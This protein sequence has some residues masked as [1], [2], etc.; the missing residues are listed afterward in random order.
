[1]KPRILQ[2]F[3]RYLAPGGEDRVTQLIETAL[4]D[5][6]QVDTHL[7]STEALLGNS[8][9]DRALAP[10][11]AVHNFGAARD[12]E[13]L[14]EKNRYSLWLIHNVLPGLSPSVYA[15]AFRL[16]V[17]VV[18]YLHNFR[19]MCTNGLLLNHG[20]PCTRCIS[21]NYWPAF[22]TAC[23]RNNRIASGMMGIVI[24]RIRQ[25]RTFERVTA[26]VALNEQQ[27]RMHIQLG[28]PEDRIRVVPNFVENVPHPPDPNPLGHVLYLGRLSQEKGVDQLVRAWAHVRANGRR[29]LI[30]GS[31]A[32]ANGLRALVLELGLQN[33]DFLGSVP[34]EE[35][36]A[37]WSRAAISVIPSI[38]HEAFPLAM[39]ESWSNMRAIVAPRLGAF[40]ENIRHESDGML[41]EPY[42]VEALAYSLQHA[43][44]DATLLEAMG[45]RGR[46]RIE[47]DFSRTRWTE[48]IA[49]VIDGALATA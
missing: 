18:H 5:R 2:I 14:Q 10:M 49:D 39:L 6:F 3:S 37:L 13:R 4:A 30:A 40:T 1:M 45:R 9:L 25:L 7:G 48:R 15:T 34:R 41:Y 46:D 8:L 42:S 23:W 20:K 11:R 28:V 17:P 32:E 43:I 16:G 33:V 19:M 27:R 38:C 29:L 22:T 47:A 31:G 35:H 26:W 36:H 24:R 21:G 44:D 12:L